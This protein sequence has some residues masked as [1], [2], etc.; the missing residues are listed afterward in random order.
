MCDLSK[1]VDKAI[2]VLKMF[3][4]E[5][6]P[7][8]LCYSGGKD[9]DCIRILA[10]LANVRHDIE[11]NITSLDTPETIRYIKS[12]PN[13]HLNFPLYPDNKPKTIW[14][15]IP[16]KLIP[17][18]R[19]I[20]YCCEE[21]KEHGGKGRLKI[22][23]VRSS[24]SFN[25][26]INS[27]EIQFISKPKTTQKY[28]DNNNIK[29]RV[30]SKGG[31]IL[32]FDNSDSHRAVEHCFRTTSTLINPILDWSESDVWEFLNYYGCKSNP[33]YQC[34]FNR[35]GC[36]GCPLGNSF[37]MKFE[38]SLYPKYKENI[39]RAFDKML[40]ERVNHGKSNYGFWSSGEAVFYWWLNIDNNQLLFDGFDYFDV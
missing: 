2:E 35:I 16:K 3:Q 8:Y 15:L 11:H 13:I 28:L 26:S 4:P 9:S 40:I 24:E 22:T 30:N 18:S 6:E 39:I 27:G 38:F 12:I 29:Y 23:G 5:N 17:P 32:N 14:N 31:I 19:S 36:I 25:R 21:L 7:Y 10:S 34:G 20:R 1:K 33:L 37:S